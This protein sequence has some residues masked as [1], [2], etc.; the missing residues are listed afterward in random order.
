MAWTND[1]QMNFNSEKCKVLHLGK[2]NPKHV[3]NMDGNPLMEDIVEKNLGIYVDNDLKFD[4]H[5][6]ETVKK[7]NKLV[8]MISHYITHK[9]KDIMIPLY[10]SL[11]RPILEYGN[12]VWSPKL[13]KHI[14][15]I[16]GVQRRYTKRII[17]AGDLSYEERLELFDLPSLEHRRFRAGM[18][19]TY[20][21]THK[22]SDYNSCFATIYLTKIHNMRT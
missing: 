17:G 18:I 4:T 8:G 1:W 22:L 14:D 13:R 10:K 21:M 12:V 2:N 19:K 9:S 3:Y 7:G 20:K 11:I 6:S 5:I 15:L 16:E